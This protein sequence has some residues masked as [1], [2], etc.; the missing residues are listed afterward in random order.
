MWIS[1]RDALILK[2]E[3]M[4]CDSINIARLTLIGDLLSAVKTQTVTLVNL[5]FE[6]LPTL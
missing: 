6:K 2:Q 1:F 3:Y 5:P 4:N